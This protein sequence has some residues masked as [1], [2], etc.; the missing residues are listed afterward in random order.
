MISEREGIMKNSF[1][2]FSL[3]FLI[4]SGLLLNGC[5]VEIIDFE[6]LAE[7]EIV[8]EVYGDRGSGPIWVKGRN[9]A[10]AT[11]ENAA[12]IFDSSCPPDGVPE[13][14]T[15][16]DSDLGSPNQD[17]GGPGVGDGGA[18]GSP[19]ENNSA[20]G[21]ILIIAENLTDKD[22][23]DLIDD[24]DDAD[25]VGAEFL[26][27][28]SE[29]G[30]VT[31]FKITIIDVEDDELAAEVELYDESDLLAAFILPQPWDNGVASVSLGPTRGVVE[32]VVTVNGSAAIDNIVFR[33]EKN[34]DDVLDTAS[35]KTVFKF[36]DALLSG[37]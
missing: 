4:V 2:I 35:T 18:A 37:K 22:S 32:M 24:P 5:A 14:C 12:V 13:Q 11:D 15:G 1:L 20:L 27:D 34:S 6:G 3:M 10:F 29:L 16:Q 17:F 28:F 33:P 31:I 7:G 9:P 23:D 8:C 36:V 21:N 30:S 26:F 25:V 19:F